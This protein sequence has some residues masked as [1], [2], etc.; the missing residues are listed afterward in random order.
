MQA[1]PGGASAMDQFYAAGTACCAEKRLGIKFRTLSRAASPA[2][3]S[4]APAE[5]TAAPAETAATA[6]ASTATGRPAA[7]G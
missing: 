3:G 7:A 1:V 2:A 4:A 6:K 5:G